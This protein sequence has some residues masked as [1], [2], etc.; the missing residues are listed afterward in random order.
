[1]K[2]SRIQTLVV[3]LVTLSLPACNASRGKPHEKVPQVTVTTV[4]SKAVTLT[5]QYVGQIQ[6]HHRIDVRA[7]EAGYVEEVPV[8]PGQKVKQDDLLFQIRRTLG[9]QKRDPENTDK[10]VSIKAAFDGVVARLPHQHGSYVQRGETLA[11]LSDS[12]EMWVYFNIPEARYLEYQAAQRR[13]QQ[14]ELKIELVLATGDKFNRPGKLAA[15]GADFHS[16]AGNVSFRADFPNPDGLLHDGQRGTV[17]ISRVQEGALV[18]PQGATFEFVG[19]R[20]VYVVDQDDVA[21]RR[22]IVVQ[23]EVDDLFVIKAG[24]L[25]VDD[26]IVVEGIR[27][28]RDG[29]KVAYDG[30]QAKKVVANLKHRSE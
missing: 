7:P 16:A 2:V 10:V 3:L 22:E 23:N 6:S 26:K 11:T 21:H 15:I 5:E 4:Q 27:R 24:T 28:V 14:D 17:L 1:M 9:Q 29:D 30:R 18:I 13:E 12:S 20:Y 8:K 19:K 25:A